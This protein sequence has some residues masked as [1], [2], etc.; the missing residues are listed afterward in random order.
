[1]QGSR[2]ALVTGASEG[3]GRALAKALAR[4]GY[5]VTAVARNEARLR[6]LVQELGPGHDHVKA[7]LGQRVDVERIAGRFAQEHYTLLVN[8]AGVG[9]GGDFVE[10]PVEKELELLRVNCEALVV[11][12]HA[13]LR[14]AKEG[15]A[16]VNTS[17]TLALVP[18]P[19]T[20]IYCATK[21]FVTSLS[22]S[23]WHEQKKRGVYVMGLCPG[24]T[25]TEFASRAGMT[26]RPPENLFES[27]EQV[28]AAAMLALRQRALPTVISGARNKVMAGVLRRLPRKT[29]M[30]LMGSLKER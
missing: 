8:N 5:Q 23:L 13:F 17:S 15:D 26:D 7:D 29:S 22:E 27:P 4:D 20:G 30:S 3:I 2:K 9:V 10:L 14:A 6:E 16:L 11:L 19:G 21:A 12:S 28:A 18:M 1:M 24:L 25:R